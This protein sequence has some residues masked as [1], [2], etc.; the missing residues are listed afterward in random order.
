MLFTA[1]S[2]RI[3]P[4]NS[5]EN[6]DQVIPIWIVS[7]SPLDVTGKLCVKAIN[8]TEDDMACFSGQ[9]RTCLSRLNRAS[10]YRVEPWDV[11]TREVLVAWQDK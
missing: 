10:R 2:L 9:N 3:Q 7:I 5:H 11:D 6:V 1:R 4:G 8:Q